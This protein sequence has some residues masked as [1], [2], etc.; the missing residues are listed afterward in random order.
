MFNVGCQPLGVCELISVAD[1]SE[2]GFIH[3]LSLPWIYC[4]CPPPSHPVV[5]TVVQDLQRFRVNRK[6]F[7]IDSGISITFKVFVFIFH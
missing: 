5:L 3:M 4:N 2:V 6:L 1:C 7:N